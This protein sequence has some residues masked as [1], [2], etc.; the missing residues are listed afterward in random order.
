MAKDPTRTLTIRRRSASQIQ[1]RFKRVKKRLS[2]FMSTST[3]LITNEGQDF[4][5]V[6]DASKLTQFA[7][8]F[9]TVLD[10]EIMRIDN[11]FE[12]KDHWLNVSIG[13]A[14]IRG[15]L[16]TRSGVERL[17]TKLNKVENYNPLL[18]NAH[19]ERS[20]LIFERAFENL[21]GVSKTTADQ[22]RRVLAEGILQGKNPAV[23]A[24]EMADRVE[25]IGITR[26]KLI[27]RTEIVE[28][29][30]T[31]SI[32]EAKILAEE[33]GQNIQMRWLTALDERVRSSHAPR[34]NQIYEFDTAQAL[35]GEPNCRCSITAHVDLDK[36]LEE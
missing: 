13:E 22:V 30:N 8:W 31:A 23:V 35:I 6:R 27:S 29:H 33:T 21:S 2:T 24:R 16:K 26:A 36:L 20:E 34:H 15:A 14:Y 25:K 11:G 28:S 1:R 10:E 7:I 32:T 19:V 18:N 12:K 3:N 17:T 4:T 5:F 9:E